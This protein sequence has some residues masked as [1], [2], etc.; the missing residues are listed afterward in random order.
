MQRFITLSE[1][2]EKLGGR[3][4][5]AIYLD[6]E[7]GRLP[8]PLKLGGRLYWPEDELDAHLRAMRGEAA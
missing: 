5:S 6:M 4:R 3:S 8:L 7:A 1:L 2:R